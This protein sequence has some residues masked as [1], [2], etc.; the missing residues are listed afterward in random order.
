M[1]FV[2]GIPDGDIF[3][4]MFPLH[5]E[6]TETALFEYAHAIGF[7]RYLGIGS[8]GPFFQHLFCVF[9]SYDY[10]V[11]GFTGPEVA[12]GHSM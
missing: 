12:D 4:S 1:A 5:L 10:H 6:K 9:F 3:I 11:Q 2:P 8:P 7:Y